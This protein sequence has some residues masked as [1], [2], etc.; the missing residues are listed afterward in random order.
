MNATKI[1]RWPGHHMMIV[2][3]RSG[4]IIEVKIHVDKTKKSSFGRPVKKESRIG[5]KGLNRV[6]HRSNPHRK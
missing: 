6:G 3:D 5:K 2:K 1:I 4:A